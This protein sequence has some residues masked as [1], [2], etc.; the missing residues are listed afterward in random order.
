MKSDLSIA[1]N[2]STRLLNLCLILLFAS[3]S[4]FAETLTQLKDENRVLDMPYELHLSSNTAPFDNA[5]VSL[6]HEDAWLFFDN[7][8][9]SD[10]IA[11]YLPNIKVNGN[12]FIE[13]TNG[14]VAIYAHGT[15][16]MPHSGSFRPLTVY[17]GEGF[18]GDSAKYTQHVY[19][20]NLGTMNN[21]IKSFKLKRGYI[22]T[23]AN[24]S[25]GL[26]Y[27]RVFIADDKDLEF[28]IMPEALDSRVSF[29]RVL[30]YEWVTKKGWCGS[31]YE[32][33]LSGSTWYYN[34][35]AQLSSTSNLEYVPM[36]AKL[37]WSPFSQINAL[38]NVSHSLGLNEPDHPEQHKDDNGE[39]V[40]TVEQAIAQWPDMLKS[41]LRVGAPATTNFEWLYNFMERCDELNYRVD[42]VAVH[43]Y[44][45]NSAQSYY[46]TLKYVHERTGR[47]IWITEWNYGANW[48]NEWWPNDP[49]GY[50][51]QNADHAYNH[52]KEI[53]E[54]FDTAS[55]IERY[56]IYNWVEDARAI[57]LNG[58]LT[59]AGQFYAENPS[60]VAFNKKKEVIPEWQHYEVPSI[61]Y[62]YLSLSNSIRVSWQDPNGE[63]ARSYVLEKKEN[64]GTYVPVYDS[65]DVSVRVHNDPLDPDLSGCITYRLKLETMTGDYLYS[66]EV[67]YFQSRGVDTVQVANLSINGDDFQ[68]C[69]FS[70]VYDEAPSVFLGITSFSNL[71]PLTT[72]VNNI[73]EK[74]FKLALRPW[75]YIVSPSMTSYSDLSVMALP[76]GTYDFGGLKGEVALVKGLGY[77]WKHVGFSQSFDTVPV[78]IA[79]QISNLN[80]CPTSV[81]IR[82]VTRTGFEVCIRVEENLSS[83]SIYDERINYIAIEPGV[84]SLEGKRIEAGYN[85]E[86]NEIGSRFYDLRYNEDFSRP[87]FF[88]QL[89]TAADDFASTLRYVSSGDGVIKLIKQRELSGGSSAIK[90][91][92]LAWL[93]MDL[94]E[95]QEITAIESPETFY[96]HVYPNPVKN[97]LHFDVTGPMMVRV[98]DLSGKELMASMSEG[99]LDISHLKSGIYLC[100]VG[101]GS[102]VKIIK[103]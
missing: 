18:T 33:N 13:R 35:Q 96:P 1:Q 20:N 62:S 88:A 38:T 16:V 42:Y 54:M 99:S 60:V 47:P 97:V 82:D 85:T 27:S 9:P 52:I 102:L 95:D 71:T 41:G 6:D 80:S 7:I 56:A 66:N 11:N 32:G 91:D 73:S 53:V 3:V 70:K 34:W 25:D 100:K 44:W 55:F 4:L 87:A 19:Y 86:G 57:V 78:V 12:P 103:E 17:S 23:F 77:E 72:R 75:E 89:Q 8:R 58:A 36:R 45:G 24:E 61:S 90:K 21:A 101:D 65:E 28:S 76:S 81:T 5:T 93:I 40:V 64:D 29:I 68:T 31:D 15:V 14:R 84:G 67:S 94:S 63:M 79:T 37:N 83:K 22:A 46:N 59:K 69:F 49:S 2:S 10:V 48:T 98:Y 43:A 74:S 92:K 39:K 51:D 26:G 50:T 30:R